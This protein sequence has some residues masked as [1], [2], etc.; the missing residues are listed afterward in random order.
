MIE[1]VARINGL[2]RENKPLIE[3]CEKIVRC[4]ECKYSFIRRSEIWC[5]RIYDD[6]CGE[7]FEVEENGYCS[8]AERKEE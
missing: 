6:M 7:P 5:D 8:W 1:R 4:K 3:F 2:S